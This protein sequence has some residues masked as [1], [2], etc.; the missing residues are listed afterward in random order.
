MKLETLHFW[1]LEQENLKRPYI[2]TYYV[3]SR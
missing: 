2:T 3:E 1:E